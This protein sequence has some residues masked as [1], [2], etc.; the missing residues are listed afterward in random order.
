[1]AV[2]TIRQQLYMALKQRILDGEYPPG[3]HLNIDVI[4]KEQGVSNSPLREAMTL[5]VKDRLVESRPN[6][7][8]Y[9]IDIT[10]E[11]YRELVDTINTWIVGAYLLCLKYQKA[12]L[13]LASMEEKLA[14]LQEAIRCG[15]D[16]ERIF[17]ILDF[18]RCF[19]TATEN[20]VYIASF[21]SDFDRLCLDYY[22]NHLGRE[23]DWQVN[24]QRANT[25]IDAV[26]NGLVD[27]V[28]VMIWTWSMPHFNMDDG[29]LS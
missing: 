4:A 24:V 9:V 26:K 2:M 25:I 22:Y 21:N 27:T 1:M 13:L 3:T 15:T 5:L 29:T 11:L 19:V 6:A 18:Q 28:S 12:G 10:P 16:R 20:K 8:M 17:A 7:G 14:A 23:I